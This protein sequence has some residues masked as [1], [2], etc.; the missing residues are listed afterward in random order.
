MAVSDI[1]SLRSNT[2]RARVSYNQVICYKRNS[3]LITIF[4]LIFSTCCHSSMGA[5]SVMCSGTEISFR[6]GEIDLIEHPK[7][8]SKSDN[9]KKNI[10]TAGLIP[11]LFDLA[12]EV[13]SE[14]ASDPSIAPPE[15]ARL[16][17]SG[18]GGALVT[19]KPSFFSQVAKHVG[20]K[21]LNPFKSPKALESS[22]P[23]E[24][25]G[26]SGHEGSMQILSD[27]SALFP[28]IFWTDTWSENVFHQSSII[29]R[30][31]AVSDIAISIELN[32]T[33]QNTEYNT[34]ISLSD[35]RTRDEIDTRLTN[36]DEEL[37]ISSMLGLQSDPDQHPGNQNG[38]L[39][40]EI[41]V[42]KSTYDTYK[43]FP[44]DAHQLD[45]TNVSPLLVEDQRTIIPHTTLR[46]IR[47]AGAR[48]TGIHGFLSGKY[49]ST[50][51][52]ENDGIL[53][54]S[55]WSW[56]KPNVEETVKRESDRSWKATS[57]SE[58]FKNIHHMVRGL[59][60]NE[61]IPEQI[62][63][64]RVIE[65][66]KQ[67]QDAQRRLFDLVCEKDVL[68]ERP[69]PLWNYSYSVDYLPGANNAQ[70]HV[71]ASREF[72]FPLQDMVDDYLDLLFATGR[73][74]KMNHTALLQRIVESD[75][76]DEP[77]LSVFYKDQVQR[78]RRVAD[79]D[80]QS[81]SWF[82]RNGLGEK[83]G[84]TAELSA[85]KAI[86]RSVMSILARSLSGLHGINVMGFSDIRLFME[87]TPD[88][89]PLSATPGIYRSNNYAQDAVQDAVRRGSKKRI[90]QHSMKLRSERDTFIQRD[91]VVETLLSQSQIA[92]PILKIFP[93]MWQRSILS[94]IVTLV[95]AVITD[96]CEGLEFQILGHKLMFSFTPIT[97]DDMLRGIMHDNFVN[98]RRVRS[99]SFEAA[100]EAAAADVGKNLKFLDKWHER[101]LGGSLL[102][103]QIASLIARIVLTLVDDILRDA[104]MNLWAANGGGLRL[105]ASLEYRVPQLTSTQ[106][107]ED[108]KT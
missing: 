55:D 10:P 93:L 101:L 13:K 54:Q 108:N 81:G 29:D 47:K 26:T 2:E 11:S 84:E 73:I 41:K 65:I 75:D 77:R 32:Q 72:N 44:E 85:Y 20:L 74:V 83:I 57:E 16:F 96:F 69:N 30:N 91:A 6:G 43:E 31:S 8:V 59:K 34:D 48:A 102:R 100:V 60:E 66:D 76:D 38:V 15:N 70:Y 46:S 98:E 25:S 24:E 63:K 103:A 18:R 1:I 33:N 5:Q 105:A 56:K 88:L 19:I 82:L 17:E 67:I 9:S 87:Q 90:K 7:V 79:A 95:T 49:R 53:D 27:K 71:S 78:R 89:P 97:E 64:D 106:M 23:L 86:C 40:Q 37:N 61:K 99:E 45:S 51:V 39:S 35:I 4:S 107:S 58:I 62:R 36:Q 42:E 68:Q 3:L 14:V 94:N 52:M 28:Q 21:Q 22:V 50:D 12:N 92:T 104:K 80:T